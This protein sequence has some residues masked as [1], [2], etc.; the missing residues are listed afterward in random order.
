MLTARNAT[1]DAYCQTS[2]LSRM[3]QLDQRTARAGQ[4]PHPAEPD[5]RLQ[6]R[7]SGYVESPTGLSPPGAVGPWPR[8]N[9]ATPSLQLHYRAFVA[10]TGCSVPALRVGTFALAVV[11]ACSFSLH[12]DDVTKRRFSRSIRKPGRASRCLHAGCRSVGIRTSSELIPE[13]GSPPGFDI[14]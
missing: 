3:A 14:A 13:E 6:E 8:L 4:C 12:V 10:T 1:L 9:N 7:G 2:E 11:A 5:V